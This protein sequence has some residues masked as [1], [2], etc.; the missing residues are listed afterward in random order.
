MFSETKQ[1]IFATKN[2][3]KAWDF[4]QEVWFYNKENDPDGYFDLYRDE[5]EDIEPGRK[6]P[7]ILNDTNQLLKLLENIPSAKLIN[8]I[9]I[10]DYSS[11][12]EDFTIFNEKQNTDRLSPISS[13]FLLYPELKIWVMREGSPTTAL[14]HCEN[15][16][17]ELK[18]GVN[19]QFLCKKYEEICHFGII[20]ETTIQLFDPS[21]IRAFLKQKLHDKI[22]FKLDNFQYLHKRRKANFALS[23]DKETRHSLFWAYTLYDFG[24]SALPVSTAHELKILSN[25]SNLFK[26]KSNITLICRGYDLQFS[27]LGRTEGEVHSPDNSNS[28]DT[29]LYYFRGVGP[30]RTNKL[31]T[32]FSKIWDNLIGEETD[33]FIISESRKSNIINKHR[34]ATI[35]GTNMSEILKRDK[36]FKRYGVTV[37]Q[38][39][40]V[41]NGIGK[42]IEG[43]MKLLESETIQKTFNSSR[44]FKKVSNRRK[45]IGSHSIPPINIGVVKSLLARAK[46]SFNQNNFLV[47][48]LLSSEALE[49]LN[50][51]SVST[52]LEALTLKLKSEAEL[53]LNVVGIGSFVKEKVIEPRIFE[54]RRQIA[55]ICGSNKEAEN[56]ARMQIFNDLRI[57]YET[58]EQFGAAEKLYE[59]V[60][61]AELEIKDLTFWRLAEKSKDKKL[62]SQNPNLFERSRTCLSNLLS[63]FKCRAS[64]LI[65][66]NLIWLIIISFF[67]FINATY[68]DKNLL[69]KHALIRYYPLIYVILFGC[70]FLKARRTLYSIIGSGTNFRRLI[71]TFVLFNYIIYLIYRFNSF[72]TPLKKTNSLFFNSVMSSLMNEPCDMTAYTVHQS[73]GYVMWLHIL[74]SVVYLSVCVASIY[75]VYTRR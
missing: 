64:T 47:S 43:M 58:H 53:E 4:E 56:N 51:L 7:F 13:I 62:L 67:L 70:L 2:K 1:I 8:T 17:E 52:S 19:H 16:D 10:L 28:T 42:E 3:A 61:K 45:E 34:P 11:L 65:N 14:F 74:I 40:P 55:R 35:A 50:C 73:L 21:R 15:S 24:Y 59:E 22:E 44:D 63:S 41:L 33:V 46:N 49:I 20:L 31:K 30:D 37:Y 66:F 23:I 9:L 75:R 72:G 26:Q 6:A 48:A 5:N 12:Y 18:N 36:Y 32:R 27:D 29:E 68:I 25:A 57:I 54:C 60:L 38:E 71:S 39:H 69:E